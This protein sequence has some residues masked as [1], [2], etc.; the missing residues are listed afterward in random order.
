MISFILCR[1]SFNENL[2]KELVN[3][4]RE[5][6]V[7]FET[8][9]ENSR[10]FWELFEKYNSIVRKFSNKKQLSQMSTEVIL[11]IHGNH[12]KNITDKYLN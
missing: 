5:G 2:E 6:L 11:T 7:G 4:Y 9:I 3:S 12:L 8:V 1:L 10:E